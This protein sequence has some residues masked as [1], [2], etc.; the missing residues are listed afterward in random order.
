MQPLIGNSGPHGVSWPPRVRVCSVLSNIRH[1][2][3]DRPPHPAPRQGY[4][5]V[6]KALMHPG[7]HGGT[8]NLINISCPLPTRLTPRDFGHRFWFSRSQGLGTLHPFPPKLDASLQFSGGPEP[9]PWS[10]DSKMTLGGSE[11]RRYPQPSKANCDFY[12]PP[13]N[14]RAF[15]EH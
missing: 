13:Q 14:N 15:S 8:P 7:P 9:L 11:L 2:P 10:L 3:P 6:T 1:C 12:F 5:G 4:T